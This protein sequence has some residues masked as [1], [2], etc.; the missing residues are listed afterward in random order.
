MALIF[1]IDKFLKDEH[2]DAAYTFE[3][4][5]PDVPVSNIRYLMFL[6]PEEKR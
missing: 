1:D 2:E 5:P 6:K 4:L 3:K